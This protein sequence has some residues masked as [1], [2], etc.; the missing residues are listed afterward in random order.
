VNFWYLENRIKFNRIIN[1]WGAELFQL[2]K[3]TC[4]DPMNLIW[5]MPA[6]GMQPY[7]R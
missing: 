5:V 1:A 4:S 6:K 3:N 7:L 2:R